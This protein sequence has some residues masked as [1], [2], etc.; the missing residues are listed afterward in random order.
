M[1]RNIIR[2]ESGSIRQIAV[3]VVSETPHFLA[4]KQLRFIYTWWVGEEPEKDPERSY[5]FGSV[6]K[7]STRERDLYK[8][9]VEFR[10]NREMWEGATMESRYRLVWHELCHVNVHTDEDFHIVLDQDGRVSFS[11]VGHDV[12]IKTFA[13]ELDKFG[14][15]PGQAYPSKVVAQAYTKYRKK[16]ATVSE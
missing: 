15:D 6:K 1:A 12:V 13:A 4:L 16:R 3:Q 14:L 2:D 10:V 9:D 8:K 11:L 7:L 5:V